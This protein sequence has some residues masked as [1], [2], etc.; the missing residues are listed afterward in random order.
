M[1]KIIRNPVEGISQEDLERMLDVWVAGLPIELDIDEIEPTY[2]L[3]LELI[4]RYVHLYFG[5]SV[6]GPQ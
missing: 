2:G 4:A 5:L 3:L 1:A 6:I